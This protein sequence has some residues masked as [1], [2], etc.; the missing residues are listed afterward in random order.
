MIYLPVLIFIFAPFCSGFFTLVIW[1]T[2]HGCTAGS[3][4][5]KEIVEGYPMYSFLQEAMSVSGFNENDDYEF[6]CIN[7]TPFE[8]FSQ[9]FLMGTMDSQVNYFQMSP[10]I[11][12]TANGL[13]T[14]VDESIFDIFS[15]VDYR[16]FLLI[17]LVPAGLG[18]YSAFVEDD[19]GFLFHMS[20]YFGYLYFQPEILFSVPMPRYAIC[21]F[22]QLANL[23]FF[24]VYFWYLQK[25][26]DTKKS[27]GG[28]TPENDYYRQKFWVDNGFLMYYIGEPFIPLPI[29]LESAVGFSLD[30]YLVPFFEENQVFPFFGPSS[31]IER[32][33]VFFCDYQLV[34]FPYS[35]DSMSIAYSQALPFDI[36]R[37]INPHVIDLQMYYDFALEDAV[38]LF[39][40]EME[41]CESRGYFSNFQLSFLDLCFLW[42]ILSIGIILALFVYIGQGIYSNWITNSG[43]FLFLGPRSLKNRELSRNIQNSLLIKSGLS[44]MVFKIIATPLYYHFYTK[45]KEKA[46]AKFT[47]ERLSK[48]RSKIVKEK[49]KKKFK[50]S[51]QVI[52][53]TVLTVKRKN[54]KVSAQKIVDK[55]IKKKKN[56]TKTMG[57][58]RLRLFYFHAIKEVFSQTL[59][60]LGV[61]KKPIKSRSFFKPNGEGLNIFSVDPSFRLFFISL[62]DYQNTHLG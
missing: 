6:L 52:L 39:Y 38:A 33:K 29:T 21:F 17:F 15:G 56:K 37:A 13:V 2:N 27:M 60:S 41:T 40:S 14:K 53:L 11:S 22:L 31:I 59:V 8:L 18:F 1:E 7:D 24:S 58:K 30:E 51:L 12:R 5:T 61:L 9:P 50:T 43:E 44:F 25:V 47:E 54:K 4:V 57:H 19:M 26:E 49:A 45:I 62:I 10:S 55:M 34:E 3:P 35:Y 20:N 48:I 23:V 32:I 28:L 16:L 46:R 42:A 36:I